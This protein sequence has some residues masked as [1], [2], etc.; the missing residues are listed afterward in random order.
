MPRVELSVQIHAPADRVYAIAKDVESFPT[1]MPDV[2]SLKVLERSEDGNRTLTEWVG[3][4]PQFR[5]SVRWKE[6]DVWDDSAHTCKFRQVQGDYDRM[7]GEW[8]FHE[9][10][11]GTLFTSVLDYELH[12]PLLGPIVQRVVQ[13]LV[14]QNLQGILNGIKTRAE[15]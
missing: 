1:F 6:E 2:K 10:N 8:L 14:K 7:E 5:L 3:Y 12:V 13:H 9:S 15:A 4:V 11:G